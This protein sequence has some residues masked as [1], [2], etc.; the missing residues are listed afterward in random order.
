MQPWKWFAFF[1][2]ETLY[3]ASYIL[4]SFLI[5][6]NFLSRR[7]THHKANLSFGFSKNEHSKDIFKNPIK[8]I[9]N[10]VI[11]LISRLYHMVI[12]PFKYTEKALFNFPQINDRKQILSGFTRTKPDKSIQDHKSS[13]AVIHLIRMML[14]VSHGKQAFISGT[15]S[16]CNVCFPVDLNRA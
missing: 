5:S 14:K 16:G 11:V 15:C 12:W 6:H 7:L 2:Y 1:L 4:S 3:I 13:F 9:T 8:H 10:A